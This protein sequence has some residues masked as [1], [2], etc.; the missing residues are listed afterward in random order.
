MAK[1]AVLDD[2]DDAYDD[3]SKQ[4]SDISNTCEGII[5][6]S[7]ED[8]NIGRQYILRYSSSKKLETKET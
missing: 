5:E 7:C 4:E 8:K 6:L 2:G 3:S 1:Q